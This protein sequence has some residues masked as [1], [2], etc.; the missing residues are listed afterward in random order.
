MPKKATSKSR[1]AGEKTVEEKTEELT[2]SPQMMQVVEVEDDAPTEEPAPVA[3]EV[4]KEELTEEKSRIA[5][6]ESVVSEFFTP[7]QEKS[8]LGYP[9]ISVHKQSLSQVYL[10]AIG[11]LLVVVLIGW[12]II[13]VSRKG[14]TFPISFV[15]QTPSPTATPTPVATPT[16]AIDKKTISIEVLNG[17]GI[18]GVAGTMKT[19]LEEK[20]YT[21]SGTGNAK[22]YEYEKTEIQTKEETAS[23]S[24]FIASDLAGSYTVGTTSANLKSS[25][26]YDVVVIVG[27]E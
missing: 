23:Y 26:P 8:S 6:Q 15:R 4:Q 19:L 13:W 21:V 27:K 17:S 16:P 18:A 12:G 22:N 5:E 25:L 24:A 11:V 7:K 9:D 1:S 3:E 20:G 10:W 2:S 14:G